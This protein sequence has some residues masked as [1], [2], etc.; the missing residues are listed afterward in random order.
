[1]KFGRHGAPK[2]EFE[3]LFYLQGFF[4]HQAWKSSSHNCSKQ[5]IHTTIK[6]LKN[7]PRLSYLHSKSTYVMFK[8]YSSLPP[9][10]HKNSAPLQGVATLF[11]TSKLYYS[12]S[13][14]L[15]TKPLKVPELCTSFGS[16]MLVE[17][18]LWIQR[19]QGK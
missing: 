3:D 8:T 15:K 18:S 10:R 9:Q 12:T 7:Q 5:L 14:P 11:S 1:M 6:N 17:I 16:I 19:S 4:H 13:P 2:T